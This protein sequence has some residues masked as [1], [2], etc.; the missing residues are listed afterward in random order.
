MKKLISLFLCLCLI[1]T[2]T[3]AFSLAGKT[4]ADGFKAFIA[5]DIHHS[6]VESV[7]KENGE[8]VYCN[9]LGLT[10]TLAPALL[11]E[12]LRQAAESDT[13]YV[14]L[15]GDLAD[16]PDIAQAKKVAQKLA[17]FEKSTKKKVFVINGNHDVD[18]T[19]KAA[20][21]R[22]TVK[23]FK[24]IY[25][26]LGYNEAL[27]VDKNTCSYTAQLKGGYRLIAIDAVDRPGEGGATVTPKLAKWIRAQAADAKKHG[28]KL[29]ALMHHPLMNH[30]TL[31]SKLLPIFVVSN[32]EEACKLFAECDIGLVF[33]GHFHQNDI[34]VYHGERDVYDAETTSLSCYPNAYRTLTFKNGSADIRTVGIERIDTSNL[35]K[36]YTKAMKKQIKTDLSGYAYERLVEDSTKRI[37]SYLSAE[38]V[39][40]MLGLTDPLSQRALELLLSALDKGFDLPLYGK[41]NSVYAY[42]KE[43]GLKIPKSGYRTLNDAACAFIAAQ[44]SGDEHFDTKS[45]LFRVLFYGVI[46]ILSH[47]ATKSA[48]PAVNAAVQ[49]ALLQAGAVLLQKLQ[50]EMEAKLLLSVVRSSTNPQV[51][52]NTLMSA[53][54]PLFVG[55][56][57]DREPQDNNVVLPVYSK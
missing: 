48:N 56:T 40:G 15:T 17:R 16:I 39:G 13:D 10:P 41:K 1:L 32:S 2:L 23:D 36:G 9:S 4:D 35:P 24:K 21:G 31:M 38:K 43:I 45:P 7:P 55:L 37:H 50:F 57:M 30:F 28:Q 44:F 18:Y 46:S 26:K 34:A 54:E 29:V 5:T 42:A 33:T 6:V 53:A 47:E 11:D 12:F 27:C 22:V 3:P 49:A 8:Y 20:P 19:G 14:F 25:A 51:M 52:L